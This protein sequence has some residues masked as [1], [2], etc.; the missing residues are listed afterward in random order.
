MNLFRWKG[1]VKFNCYTN[2]KEL[3]FSCFPLLPWGDDRI[4]GW[5]TVCDF[6]FVFV[7]T[8]SITHRKGN[9]GIIPSSG[10]GGNISWNPFQQ[11]K[12]GTLGVSPYIVAFSF[13][14]QL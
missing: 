5:H 8:I 14:T 2:V 4:T 7:V 11:G 3:V 12:I 10:E 13:G 6:S 1:A 9:M